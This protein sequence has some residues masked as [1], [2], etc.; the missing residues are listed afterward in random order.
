[1]SL[2]LLFTTELI[3]H[4]TG[5]TIL[6]ETKKELKDIGVIEITPSLDR[7][8]AQKLIEENE[9]LIE[10]H[11]N[12]LTKFTLETAL[13]NMFDVVNLHGKNSLFALYNSI[14]IDI[15]QAVAA[16]KDYITLS[17]DQIEKMKTLFSDPP[18]MDEKK[19]SYNRIF[20]FILGC[21]NNATT[22]DK[23]K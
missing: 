6:K 12:K 4:S 14:L 11:R 2:K 1:M 21:L 5:E 8:A 16:K 20:G 17:D 23:P 22:T 10:K 9:K 18:A 19:R 15:H 7:N 13:E 3:D